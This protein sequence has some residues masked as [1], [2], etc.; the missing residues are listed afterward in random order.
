MSKKKDPAFLFYSSDFLAGVT[1]LTMVERGQYITLL[2]MQHQKGR[3]TQKMVD[4]VIGDATAYAAAYHAASIRHDAGMMPAHDVLKKFVQDENGMWYNE[5][6]DQEMQ[7][8]AQ[9]SQKQSIKAKKR[10]KQSDESD[11][12]AD[13]AAY[14]VADA[15]AYAGT[16]AE[17]MPFIYNNNSIYKGNGKKR[18]PQPPESLDDVKLFCSTCGHDPEIGIQF[19]NYFENQEPKWHDRDGRPVINWKSK[20]TLWFK[21]ENRLQVKQPRK[22]ETTFKPE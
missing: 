14:P 3:L 1:D 5:R 8:R 7:K 2:C 13:A 4:M 16:H 12:T 15:A 6:L 17:C 9:H 19:W 22:F 10:W 21:P 11:A 18:Q 20:L